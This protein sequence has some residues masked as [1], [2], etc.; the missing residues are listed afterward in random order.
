MPRQLLALFAAVLL[1]GCG[2]LANMQNRSVPAI[3]PPDR[4]TRTFGG[5]ANDVRWVGEQISRVAAPEES[6]EVP[7]GLAM[8][9]YFGLVDLPF[10]L[11][12]DILT[13]PKVVRDARTS[14]DSVSD[15]P[16]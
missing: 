6:W 3:G 12:G 4:E 10:S 1:S 2:T 5:V 11:V 13:L 8:A 9:G 7:V 14:S 16:N 15:T